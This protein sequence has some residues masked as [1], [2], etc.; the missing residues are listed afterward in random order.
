VRQAQAARRS[1]R[2]PAAFVR[3][4]FR[5][6][7]P[8]PPTPPGTRR[9]AV[10][11]APLAA[12]RAGAGLARCC[13]ARRCTRIAAGA[14]P[15]ATRC[16]PRAAAAPC[17]ARAGAWGDR[18]R[19]V[20]RRAPENGPRTV[21][22][23]PAIELRTTRKASGACVVEQL[24]G[25]DAA[26][27]HQLAQARQQNLHS[28]R[29]GGLCRTPVA[30]KSAA[31]PASGTRRMRRESDDAAFD[32]GLRADA[33]PTRSCSSLSRVRWSRSG[34][35]GRTVRRSSRARDDLRIRRA[36][37]GVGVR[38]ARVPV[39]FQ[40]VPVEQ[41]AELHRA[42]GQRPRRR[43][44]RQP[45]PAF[46]PAETAAAPA[47]G[48]R[49]LQLQALAQRRIG[50]LGGREPADGC[51]LPGPAPADAR[52]VCPAAP[53]ASRAGKRGQLAQGAD[54]PRLGKRLQPRSS[55]QARSTASGSGASAAA[56][57][58]GAST[59]MPVPPRAARIA[60]EACCAAARL[61]SA[62]GLAPSWRSRAE[63]ARSS[64]VA[65]CRGLPSR[66][67]AP[68]TSSNSVASPSGCR[69]GRRT[70]TRG[71]N[72]CAQRS[73]AA[74]ALSSCCPSALRQAAML[75]SMLRR[76]LRRWMHRYSGGTAHPVHKAALL[77]TA[78]LLEA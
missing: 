4:M 45:A 27:A 1:M 66:R 71:E 19:D 77:Q 68:A 59:Q 32:A 54:A 10:H 14:L 65:I 48:H 72:R 76:K 38:A 16:R 29:F 8:L 31:A 56:S 34:I 20:L 9:A 15:S 49:M 6:R 53:P 62:A 52:R 12:P 21:R 60:A 7:P 63:S 23:P 64:A 40:C 43:A 58:P 57:P 2:E 28:S 44:R 22:L 42:D 33:T 55:L 41:Q 18:A 78:S 61:I 73:R 69:G 25:A 46:R 17:A 39:A 67:S 75:W 24:R 35:V 51:R 11:H 36:P 47:T 3:R 26:F 50:G 5:L 74:R 13:R 37:H 70:S 30:S